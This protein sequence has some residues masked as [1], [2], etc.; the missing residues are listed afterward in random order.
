MGFD[1]ARL[2][3]GANVTGAFVGLFDD[4]TLDLTG[5]MTETVKPNVIK[6]SAGD[7]ELVF[8]GRGMAAA[9]VGGLPVAT[10]GTVDKIALTGPSGE[11]FKLSGLDWSFVDLT[12]ALLAEESDPTAMDNFVLDNRFTYNGSNAADV[13]LMGATT[14]AGVDLTFAGNDRFK[15]RGGDDEF[16]LGAGDDRAQGG[17]GNDT[18][19]GESGRDKIQG[20]SGNDFLSGGVDNDRL[21]GNS[22]FDDLFGETGSDMLKGGADNDRLTGGDDNDLLVGDAGNDLL[23]GESGDDVLDGGEGADEFLFTAFAS[24]TPGTALGAD[25][26]RDFVVGEDVLELGTGHTFT[27]TSTGDQVVVLTNAEGDT[28]TLRGVATG[29][30]TIDDLI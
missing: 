3:I 5:L 8:K 7:L 30:L 2:D 12:T 13:L 21:F 15:L 25:T 26:I 24:D 14:D 11:I 23:R 17:T 10:G 1:M 19:L 20:Q 16:A 6:L 18:I 29:A 22:G 28:I 9:I 27:I 4:I